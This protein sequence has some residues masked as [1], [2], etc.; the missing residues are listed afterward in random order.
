MSTRTL[1]IV[2]E[3]IGEVRERMQVLGHSLANELLGFDVRLVLQGEMSQLEE[4]Y[5]A[6][7]QE[8]RSLLARPLQEVRRSP[9]AALAL[10]EEETDRIAL[11]S[12]I[13]E[14]SAYVRPATPELL[15]SDEEEDG[16][17]PAVV[18]V[19]EIDV[20]AAET[21]ARPAVVHGLRAPRRDW[22]RMLE[23]R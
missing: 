1:L 18:T 3:E 16:D 13:Q 5:A 21:P 2:Q 14:A 9:A 4:R 20:V 7:F 6:L 19:P 22:R 23:A 12:L 8:K 17:V 15:V 10:V 11:E